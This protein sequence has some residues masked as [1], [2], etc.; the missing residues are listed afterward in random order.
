MK[1]ESFSLVHIHIWNP[2]SGRFAMLAA[3]KLAIPYLLTEHDPF[4]LSAIKDWLKKRLIREASKIITVSKKNQKLISTLYPFMKSRIVT[5][6]NGIDTTWFESQLLS[7]SKSDREEYREDVFGADQETPIVTCIAELH[8]RKGIIYLL[9]AAKH[10]AMEEKKIKFVI[11][12]TGEEKE[13]YMR[14]I[15]AEHL[16]DYVILLG[17]RHDIPQILSS[18]DLFVLPSLNEAFGLVL[19]EAMMAKLPIVA[20]NNGGIPEIIDDGKNGILVPPKDSKALARAIEKLLNDEKLRET[21][22]EKNHKDVKNLYD[23]KRM[24][25]STEEIYTS[26][27]KI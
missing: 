20:T 15:K 11:V 24:V 5:I 23:V 25:K 1:R 22:S 18:S 8:K 21:M 16:E 4:E 3:Q 12:G 26:I 6:P 27:L 7:L 13:G 17:R 14:F 2:A 10:F 9:E 19:L